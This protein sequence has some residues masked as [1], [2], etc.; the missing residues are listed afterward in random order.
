[1]REVDE[2]N[3]TIRERDEQVSS[4]AMDVD[5]VDPLE[6]FVEGVKI[7]SKGVIIVV[8]FFVSFNLLCSL[9][10]G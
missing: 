4:M 8:Y 6:T 1:M 2:S 9:L 3:G 10:H 7:L 5:D